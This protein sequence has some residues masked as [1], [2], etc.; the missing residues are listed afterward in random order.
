[1]TEIVFN[2]EASVSKPQIA[3]GISYGA[4]ANEEHVKNAILNAVNKMKPC[5]IGSVLLFLT[6]GYAQAPQ[7]AIKQAAKT[8]GTPQIF[9]CTSTGILNEDEWLLDAE[10]AVAMVFPQS[11]GL[12][13]KAVL[14]SKGIDPDV[15]FCICSPNASKIAVNSSMSP[16]F[17]SITSDYFGDG[18]YSIWQS[19]QITEN[20]Y[21]HVGFNE[22]LLKSI[23]VAE[24]V[25]PL[26]PIQKIDQSEQH[27]LIEINNVPA[28][29]N[30][31]SLSSRKFTCNW[32]TTTL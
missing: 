22:S 23:H 31:F 5:T 6:N 2:I 17:G 13:P 19:G 24:G 29:E 7:N 32:F 9:G 20:E 28:I 4:I 10:G 1:M 8:A 3:T 16:Q 21:M 14:E 27:A 30:L 18:P 12:T 26:S 11:C 15:L 25:T